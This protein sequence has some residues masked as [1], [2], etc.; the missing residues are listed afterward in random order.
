[1]TKCEND[2][3]IKNFKKI[4]NFSNYILDTHLS[5]IR[6]YILDIHAYT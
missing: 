6:I 5:Q 2:K 3:K 1:M 4:N